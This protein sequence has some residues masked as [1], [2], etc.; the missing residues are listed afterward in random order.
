MLILPAID[1]PAN[2]II[3]NPDESCYDLFQVLDAFSGKGAW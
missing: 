2:P 1:Y 3:A